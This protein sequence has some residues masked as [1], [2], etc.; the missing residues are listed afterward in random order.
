MNCN[1][2]DTGTEDRAEMAENRAQQAVSGPSVDPGLV[3]TDVAMLSAL[4]N[5][6]RYELLR[7]IAAAEEGVCVCE[8]EAA[9]GVSQSAVS[10]ALSR[11]HETG[12]VN[13]RKEESWRYYRA[14]ETAERLLNTLDDLRGDR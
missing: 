12:L 5:D 10:Q 6:T 14:T 9:V 1:A 13:R 7:L 3:A 8:L 4:G 11:L 2:S